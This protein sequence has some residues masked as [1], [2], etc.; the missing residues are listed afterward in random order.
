MDI[1]QSEAELK[2]I[3][4]ESS[5]IHGMMKAMLE[6]QHELNLK[7]VGADWPAKAMAKT[8]INYGSAI[9]EE[10]QELQASD[11][12]WKWWKSNPAKPDANNM[13]VELVDLLHFAMSESIAEVYTDINSSDEECEEPRLGPELCMGMTLNDLAFALEEGFISAFCSEDITLRSEGGYNAVLQRNALHSLV[14]SALQGTNTVSIG[15]EQGETFNDSDVVDSSFGDEEGGGNVFTP[16]SAINW[17]AFW[18]V[19]YHTGISLSDVYAT[20]MGKAVLNAFRIS[21]G[22]KAGTYHREWQNGLQDNHYLMEYFHTF[23]EENGL[24]PS[25]QQ[26]TNWL[27]TAYDEFVAQMA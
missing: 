7:F 27:N 1:T 25:I 11:V 19:A 2:N 10:A 5:V 4:G 20:Y 26:T 21:K 12:S 17:T 9:L 6:M 23:F 24:F 14:A 15:L 8:E 22:D 18:S 13:K 3:K 16:I